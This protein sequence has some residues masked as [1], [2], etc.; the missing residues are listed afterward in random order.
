VLDGD[1]PGSGGG[2]P[3]RDRARAR[4]EVEDQPTLT[5]PAGPDQLSNQRAVT[6]EVSTGRVRRQPPPYHGRP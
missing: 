6:Q 3:G 5:R 1:H 4:P 2:Q